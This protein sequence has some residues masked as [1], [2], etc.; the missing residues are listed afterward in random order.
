MLKTCIMLYLME[1][2][3]RNYFSRG[4]RMIL[5]KNNI[6]NTCLPLL[7]KM[8]RKKILMSIIVFIIKEEVIL[9]ILIFKK[10]LTNKI[11]ILYKNSTRIKQILECLLYSKMPYSTPRYQKI[12][13]FFQ[14]Q[15]GRSYNNKK[16]MILLRK[17]MI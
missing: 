14:Y 3:L 17:Q 5:V 12:T 7:S 9:S 2:A 4:Y 15:S 11:K 16:C 1:K 8:F 13:T 6:K 10:S